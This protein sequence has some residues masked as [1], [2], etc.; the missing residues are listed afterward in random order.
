MNELEAIKAFDA[1]GDPVR[2]VLVS[3]LALDGP[4]PMGKLGAGLKVSRQGIA[5][6]LS[7][8][9]QSGLVT[10]TKQGREYVVRL[11]PDRIEELEDLLASFSASW[12][13]HR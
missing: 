1:L 5:Q 12:R 6:H 10:R 9:E 13:K 8:M 11:N 3:R 4:T 2:F 7:L